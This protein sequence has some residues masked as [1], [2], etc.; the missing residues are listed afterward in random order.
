[1][2]QT[3]ANKAQFDIDNLSIG[4]RNLLRATPKA[5]TPQA[6]EAARLNLSENLVKGEVYTLQLWGTCS[7]SDKEAAFVAYWGGG[8]VALTNPTSQLGGMNRN[9]DGSYW[10]KTFTVPDSTHSDTNNAWLNIYNGPTPV[11][12]TGTTYNTNLVKWKLEKGNRATDWTPA[13]EDTSEGISAAQDAAD[14]AQATADTAG[15]PNLSPFFD[16]K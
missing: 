8:R 16:K 3:A 2:A 5:S 6:Y 7:R 10:W 15:N 1:M 4:G 9:E 14:K 13:P 12:A 11:G